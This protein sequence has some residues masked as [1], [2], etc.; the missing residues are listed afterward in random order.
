ML[1]RSVG[2]LLGCVCETTVKTC[3]V[4]I[5][6]AV[7]L[8]LLLLLAL[9][10]MISSRS[11]AHITIRQVEMNNNIGSRNLPFRQRI[12]DCETNGSGN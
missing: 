11:K 1:R 6:G 2:K 10:G 9:M 12:F 4:Y 3:A 8:L 7:L 5:A